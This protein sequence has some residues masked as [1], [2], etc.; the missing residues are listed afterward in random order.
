M[1]KEQESPEEQVVGETDALVEQS[2]GSEESDHQIDENEVPG[3][4]VAELQQQ[5]ERAQRKA[6][7]NWNTALRVQADMDN[8]KKRTQ[9]D[10]ENAHKFALE[11]F[12]RELLTVMDS[13]DLGI[14][15]A[16]SNAPEVVKLREGSELTQTGLVSIHCLPGV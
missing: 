13:L 12:A 7:E 16:S 10:L 4:S 6:E 8:L 14:Q 2:T 5:L 3:V 15:A 9:I 11:K 1:S